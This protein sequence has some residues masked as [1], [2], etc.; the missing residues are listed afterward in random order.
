MALCGDTQMKRFIA[1]TALAVSLLGNAAAQDRNIQ[2]RRI[3]AVKDLNALYRKANAGT[4]L[5]VA[6]GAGPIRYR[7]LSGRRWRADALATVSRSNC[8]DGFL[9]YS[10][11]DDAL[12]RDAIEGI[13]LIGL[14]NP[15]SPYSLVSG[16]CRRPPFLQ[17]LHRCDRVRRTIQPSSRWKSFRT[18]AFL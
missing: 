18:W 11:H 12:P 9:V 3:Y 17:C 15:Y 8:T 5:P 13:K 14:T 16:N 4:G 1:C 7:S 2:R 10:F 6:H